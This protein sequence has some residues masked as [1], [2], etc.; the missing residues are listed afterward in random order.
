ME[1]YEQS[2][3]HPARSGEHQKV[4][5]FCCSVRC[6][7]H[8]SCPGRSEWFQVCLSN[9]GPLRQD[10]CKRWDSSKA[11][12]DARLWDKSCMVR[13]SL[14]HEKTETRK[15]CI[16]KFL[17]HFNF[18]LLTLYFRTRVLQATRESCLIGCPKSLLCQKTCKLLI[19][20]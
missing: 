15:T 18:M 11:N 9:F 17:L 7:C 3:Q 2:T 14:W 12:N 6:L 16:N 4:K 20:I 19:V 5:L 8:T 13:I 10:A 1:C